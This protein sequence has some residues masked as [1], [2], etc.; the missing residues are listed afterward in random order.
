MNILNVCGG[1]FLF[2]L[3][4]VIV[5][6]NTHWSLA[7]FFMFLYLL[8]SSQGYLYSKR[9]SNKHLKVAHFILAIYCRAENNRVYDKRNVKLRPGYLGKWIEFHIPDAKR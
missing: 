5:G 4:A 8:I 7:I 9:R 1:L 3:I 6:I 2:T